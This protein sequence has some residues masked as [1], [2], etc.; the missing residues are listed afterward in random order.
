MSEIGTVS[1]SDR[2]VTLDATLTEAAMSPAGASRRVSRRGRRTAEHDEV[3]EAYRAHY[4]D[5]VRFAGLVAPEAAM[6]EDLVHEAFVKLYSAW[7]RIDDHD[8]VGAT[9]GARC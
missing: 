7:R 1:A 2:V 4:S 3:L 5:L 9:S 6:A 8:K